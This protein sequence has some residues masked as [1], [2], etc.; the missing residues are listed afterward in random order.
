MEEPYVA[1]YATGGEVS[2]SLGLSGEYGD[3]ATFDGRWIAPSDANETGTLYAVVR[4]RR[5]G[6]AWALLP[7][8][9]RP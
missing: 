9:V 4:D 3:P 2:E 1:I 7:Y 5:G 6:Q 8:T